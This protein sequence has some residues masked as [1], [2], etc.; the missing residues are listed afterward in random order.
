MYSLKEIRQQ[1]KK[2][3]LNCYVYLILRP[4]GIPFYVGKGRGKRILSHENE[5][6]LFSE[7]KTWK[8]INSHKLSVI[9]KIWKSGNDISYTIDSW[10]SLDGPAGDREIDLI[11][12]YKRHIDKGVLTNISIGGEG[13]FGL[14]KESLI[15]ISKYKICLLYTSPSPRD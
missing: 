2:S 3:P 8:G 10:H 15:D 1:I 6:K 14:S 9:K 13:C 11:K 4:N 12:I 5:A 7:G